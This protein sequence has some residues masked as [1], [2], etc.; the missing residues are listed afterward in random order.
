M[1]E[2][3]SR[4]FVIEL[5]QRT[6]SDKYYMRPKHYVFEF[7]SNYL[8]TSVMVGDLQ[9]TFHNSISLL[10][11][12]KTEAM[13]YSK[14]KELGFF[15]MTDHVSKQEHDSGSAFTEYIEDELAKMRKDVADM[16]ENIIVAS[17][18]WI[19]EETEEEGREFCYN[20]NFD[21][22]TYVLDSEKNPAIKDFGLSFGFRSI[23]SLKLGKYVINDAVTD[24]EALIGALGL[25]DA[26][27]GQDYKIGMRYF[28]FNVRYRDITH[29]FDVARMT[30]HNLKRA[31]DC[32]IAH[33]NN[34]ENHQ[35]YNEVINMLINSFT[36]GKDTMTFLREMKQQGS[37]ITLQLDIN[38]KFRF[39]AYGKQFMIP[40]SITNA[41]LLEIIG[42]VYALIDAGMFNKRVFDFP[43]SARNGVYVPGDGACRID[44]SSM[45]GKVSIRSK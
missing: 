33:K 31:Y 29:N 16:P 6:N 44:M 20:F 37:D 30:V 39:A 43:Y 38:K 41:D 34:F 24:E 14:V 21:G 3:Y 40:S 7:F 8:T 10:L 23:V 26:M 27:Y 25:F 17:Y 2:K 42:D 45:S 18:K 36:Q 32:I 19:D 28:Q 12:G 4:Y 22:N 13:S 9:S 1:I 11:P 15:S 5:L 35:I